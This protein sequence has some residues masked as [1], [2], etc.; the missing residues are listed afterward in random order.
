M[1]HEV[2]LRRTREGD[3]AALWEIQI[4]AIRELGK[5]HYTQAEVDAWS[6]YHDGSLSAERLEK[7]IPGCF[8]IVAEVGS[9]I[10]AFGTLDDNGEVGAVYVRPEYAR[11]GIGSA[12]LDKL[13][14]EARRRGLAQVRAIAS[15]TGE[16]FYA[17]AGFEVQERC[18]HEFP[19]GAA[20]DCVW[21]V[22]RLD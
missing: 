17:K 1:N 11:Q 8:G 9:C 20:I 15:L 12:V 7:S 5:S 2:T 16:A 13:L 18:E 4:T 19:S 3:G 14:S 10:V 22:K 6:G 21:M